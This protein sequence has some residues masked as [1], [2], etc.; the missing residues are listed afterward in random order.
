V[1]W[2]SYNRSLLY[3]PVY[4]LIIFLSRN[5][6]WID[7]FILLGV[8]EKDMQKHEKERWRK[9]KKNRVSRYIETE[10]LI[11]VDKRHA[12]SSINHWHVS[13]I[14]DDWTKLKSLESVLYIYV[15]IR[16]EADKNIYRLVP[17]LFKGSISIK[18]PYRITTSLTSEFKFG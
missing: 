2:C 8:S 16:N 10:Q 6:L 13:N 3:S 11:K 17:H 12:T 9:W 4:L 15:K 7:N 14:T 5:N 1:A 18:A